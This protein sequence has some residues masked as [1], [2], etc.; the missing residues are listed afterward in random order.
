HRSARTAILNHEAVGIHRWGRTSRRQRLSSEV[1]RSIKETSHN[2]IVAGVSNNRLRPPILVAH[3]GS[4][5]L[6]GAVGPSILDHEHVVLRRGPVN[7]RVTGID[8]FASQITVNSKF[9]TKDNI[10]VSV[11]CYWPKPCERS[12][13]VTGQHGAASALP[14]KTSRRGELA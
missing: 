5:P 10:P 8:R 7:N 1:I 9:S 6:V 4:G 14:N 2:D 11:E 13:A 3:Q 12:C